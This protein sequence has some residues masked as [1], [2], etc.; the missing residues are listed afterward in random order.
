MFMILL[1]KVLTGSGFL[2]PVRQ[3]WMLHVLIGWQRQVDRVRITR[4]TAKDRGMDV[5]GFYGNVNV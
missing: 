4:Q 2:P 1:T 3:V 5:N